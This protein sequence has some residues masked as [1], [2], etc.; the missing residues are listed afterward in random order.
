MFDDVIDIDGD[1]GNSF[2]IIGAAILVFVGAVTAVGWLLPKTRV[3]SAVVVGV[4]A[5]MAFSALFQFMLI[6]STFQAFASSSDSGFRT[7]FA[8]PTPEPSGSYERL[9]GEDIDEPYISEDYDYY[10]SEFGDNPYRD[11]IKV[12]LAYCV[13]LGLFWALCSV[14]TGHVAFRLLSVA[15]LV[16]SIPA[17]TIALVVSHPTWWQVALTAGGGLLLGAAGLRLL[18]TV[19]PPPAV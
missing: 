17:T 12:I 6:F 13:A 1:G 18:K 15:I 4:G 11:D 2:M 19:P 10:P 8:V 5:I 16:L 3:L 9:Q 14:L 7:S